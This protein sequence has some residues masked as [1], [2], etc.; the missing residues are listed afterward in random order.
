MRRS[1]L[2]SVFLVIP[3]IINAQNKLQDNVFLKNGTVVRGNIFEQIPDRSV[4]IV[5]IYGDSLYLKIGKIERLTREDNSLNSRLAESG[6]WMSAGYKIIIE[7]NSYFNLDQ[8]GT[9]FFKFSIINGIRLNRNFFYGFGLGLRCNPKAELSGIKSAYK[10]FM[11]Y[12]TTDLRTY[13][14]FNDKLSA[15]FA[16]DIGF[17]LASDHKAY[18]TEYQYINC[19]GKILNPSLGAIIRISDRSALNLGFGYEMN[20][21]DFKGYWIFGNNVELDQR[22]NKLVSSLGINAG[23]SF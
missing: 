10:Q 18:E 21:M 14:P 5:T 13:F 4:G 7:A 3:L 11:V 2:F 19:R 15:Y 23:I 17:A 22:D 6:K 8:F 12:V 20:I 16:F 1:L 9:D